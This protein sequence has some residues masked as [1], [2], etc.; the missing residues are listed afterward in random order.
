MMQ[1]R[2]KWLVLIVGWTF[3]VLGIAG[4]FLPILQGILFL[5]IGMIILS[6]EY[7]WA[8]RLLQKIRERFPKAAAQFQEASEKAR[9]WTRHEATRTND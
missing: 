8:H 2:K 1:I 6:S 9:V 5:M 7:V 4:L 3:I